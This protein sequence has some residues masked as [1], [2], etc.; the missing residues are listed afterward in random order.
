MR[1]LGYG[2][3]EA[4]RVAVGLVTAGAAAPS[5]AGPAP[6]SNRGAREQRCFERLATQP[7]G[8]LFGFSGHRGELTYA[9]LRYHYVEPGLVLLADEEDGQEGMYE[10]DSL[11]RRMAEGTLWVIRGSTTGAT[12]GHAGA[13]DVATRNILE[14]HGAKQ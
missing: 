12:D 1:S 6:D 2:Q 11:A 4:Q 13:R 5:E 3:E 9:R 10:L 14:S 8:T 7:V